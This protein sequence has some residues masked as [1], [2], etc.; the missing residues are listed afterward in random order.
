MTARELTSRNTH[1]VVARLL[2]AEPQC[3]RVLDIPCGEG[4]FLERVRE[5]GRE[6]HGADIVNRAA[7]PAASFTGA[8][9]NAPL[10]FPDRSFDAVVCIDGIEHLERPF[11]FVRECHRVIRP[12]GVL[13]VSTPN[14]SAL[15][16][17]WRYL[18]T[19]FHN[20]G[21]VPLNERDPTPWHHVNLLSFPALR[22]LLHR[23]GFRITAIATNRIKPVSWLYLPL[24][25][26]ALLVTAV[27]LRRWEHDT[28]Q[29]RRNGEILRQML[30]T[31]VAFGETMIVKAVRE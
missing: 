30:T 29:R 21:K 18:L 24:W 3:V 2:Q 20:K 4:A 16:S 22:Y 11:D 7:L 19:G 15:R 27:A 13:I 28:D 17:R 12:G 26:V 9:M 31:C 25:P 1:A 14:I 6:G 10:P 8:D 5:M 23:H